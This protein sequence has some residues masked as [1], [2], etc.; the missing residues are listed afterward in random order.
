MLVYL[1]QTNRGRQGEGLGNRRDKHFT[2]KRP[3]TNL[4]N[5]FAHVFWPPRPSL[6]LFRIQMLISLRKLVRLYGLQQYIYIMYIIIKYYKTRNIRH[7]TIQKNGRFGTLE[8][9]FIDLLRIYF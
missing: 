8:S 2:S 4:A 1:G 7:R 6:D 3:Q 9:S 5:N